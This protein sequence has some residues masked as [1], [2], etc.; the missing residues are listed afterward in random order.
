MPFP[1]SACT[2]KEVAGQALPNH[3][4]KQQG[5]DSAEALIKVSFDIFPI[6]NHM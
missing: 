6:A 4:S 3:T 5:F 1:S 2:S